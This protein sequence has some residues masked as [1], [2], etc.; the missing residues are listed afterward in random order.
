M[1]LARILI[2]VEMFRMIKL[3]KANTLHE[4]FKKCTA[5]IM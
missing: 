1:K 2:S 3:A 4:D 5:L